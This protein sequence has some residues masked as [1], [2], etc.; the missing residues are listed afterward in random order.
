[1]PASTPAAFH[2]EA[3]ARLGIKVLNTAFC[4]AAASFWP[5]K[6]IAARAERRLAPIVSKLL[7]TKAI[8]TPCRTEQRA[9]VA[10]R[11][12]I[13]SAAAVLPHFDPGAKRWRWPLESIGLELA[14]RR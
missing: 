13:Q 12:A 5:F 10:C 2:A 3:R 4:V 11:K 9:V 7:G 1:M 14:N 8:A 6:R